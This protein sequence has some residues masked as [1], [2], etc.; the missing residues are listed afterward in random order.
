[1]SKKTLDDYD[2]QI[3]FWHDKYDGDLELHEY[4]GLSWE[5]YAQL[6]TQNK[7]ASIGK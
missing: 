5:E 6:V 1:M 3:A 4:L 7:Q 2:D